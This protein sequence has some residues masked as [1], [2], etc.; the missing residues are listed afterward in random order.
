M[1]TKGNAWATLT[2]PIISMEKFIKMQT[3][4]SFDSYWL[5]NEPEQRAVDKKL[6]ETRCQQAFL[7]W[8]ISVEL[9]PNGYC[10]HVKELNKLNAQKSSFSCIFNFNPW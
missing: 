3:K 5:A 8:D 2:Q 9:R 6:K 10:V 7:C 1:Q 4:A